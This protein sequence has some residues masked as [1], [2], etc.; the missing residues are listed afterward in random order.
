MKELSQPNS[1][2]NLALSDITMDQSRILCVPEFEKHKDPRN[3]DPEEGL[4]SE[5]CVKEMGEKIINFNI[6]LDIFSNE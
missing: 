3:Q 2:F 6:F 1:Q 5:E 4:Q